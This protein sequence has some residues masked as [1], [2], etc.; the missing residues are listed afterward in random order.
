MKSRLFLLGLVLV[1]S[2]LIL[3]ACAPAG[4]VTFL[5]TDV[6]PEGP[7][8]MEYAVAR[9]AALA[10]VSERYGEQTP[11]PSSAWTRESP[12]P[13]GWPGPDSYRY[14]AGDW[15]VTISRLVV[16]PD[17]AAYR[18]LVTNQNSAFWWE[19]EV[20]AAGQVTESPPRPSATEFATARDA[21]LGYLAERYGEQAPAQGLAWATGSII[22][23][24]HFV[25]GGYQF[26]AA[27]WTVTVTYPLIGPRRVTYRVRVASEAAGFRW[28]GHVDGER[29]EVYGASDDIVAAR[30]AALV[31]IRGQ[32]GNQ[33]PAS[34]LTWMEELTTP[35]LLPGGINYRFTA[36]DWVV[37]VDT[38][39]VPLET[40]VY[41]VTVDNAASG[42]RWQGR[43]DATGQVTDV[44]DPIPVKAPDP[45]GA[46]DLA[47]AYVVRKH[48]MGAPP[49]LNWTEENTTP[50][51][52]GGANLK[53]TAGD[54]EVTIFC[55]I[56]PPEQ[57]V[58]KV[59][60]ANQATG[61]LWEG[62]VDAA[63]NVQ[64]TRSETADWKTYTNE[65]YGYSLSYPSD[66]TF[67]PMPAGCKK[68]APAKRPA[69]CLCFLNAEDPDRVF[70]Q[71]YT[72]EKDDLQG[73]AF[74]I[75]RTVYDLLPGADL[76]EWIREKYPHY[77][78]IPDEPNA[79]VGGIP[80]VRF[81]TPR[82]PM[83]PNYEEIYFIKD[84]GFFRIHML[85]VDEKTNREL[86]DQISAALDITVETSA[87]ALPVVAWYGSVVSLPAGSQYDDYLSLLPEGAG[88][89]GVEGA[90]EAI[91]AQ[92]VALRDQEEPGKYAHFWGT[93]TCPALDYGGCELVV[94]RLRVDGPGPT[95]DPDPVEGWE[96][97]VYSGPPGLQVDDYFVLVGDFN[98]RYGIWSLDST[99]RGQLESL[100][101]TGTVI[102]VWGKVVAGVMDGNGTQIQVNRFEIVEEPSGPVPPPPEW[103]EA[104]DGMEVYI[105]EDYRYQLRVPPTA[106]ITEFRIQ[107]FPTDELP[108]GMTAEEYMAQLRE[109]YGDKLCV[110][111]EHG[112]GYMYISA[113]PNEAFRYATCGRT[114]IG[115]G[116]TVG[117]SEEVSIMGQTYT[118]GGYEFIGA[119][120]PCEALECHNETFVV[121][122]EDGTRIEYGARPEPT[123]S[124][125][126]YLMKGRD[127]LL[128][129]LASYEPVPTR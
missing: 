20:G 27:D 58:Y 70:L 60:V 47:L 3:S 116:E 121:V 125:K 25:S 41:Q 40:R 67:G 66:C 97:T 10:F 81:Y 22:L 104:D 126:D 95:F 124:Y 26:T 52:I 5:T 99:I 7:V 63:G 113:P 30:D 16:L 91:E 15:L 110:H 102:R 117:R 87:V 83:A 4:A 28:E 76:I 109:R 100:R 49:E 96:G 1:L 65:K 32:S 105:N 43:V 106:K 57:I 13:D 114:G 38:A 92:I 23:E 72:G 18:V 120:R 34:G 74:S 21:A 36:G 93:L 51:L 119:S 45:A 9:D 101:D 2:T 53:Y 61:F 64:T 123:A 80:A 11:L 78:K 128:Q 6:T 68:S 111:I 8:D 77:E 24:G 82:S 94:T 90:N 17:S 86:Y 62:Q 37:T 108:E 115:V 42:F 79:K 85:D 122:L 127:M 19:G 103:P 56:V 59:T 112:L 29:H 55:P 75:E 50:G 88:E 14:T 98:V 12:A 84:G 33:T 69:E 54:W 129:I 73:A 107:G 44:P 71:A 89:I 31:Y 39:V 118:A 48:G 46:R 35:E